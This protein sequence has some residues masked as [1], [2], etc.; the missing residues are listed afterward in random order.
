MKT[1]RFVLTLL[2]LSLVATGLIVIIFQPAR[3]RLQRLA[4]TAS[5]A[6][7]A[8][9]GDLPPDFTARKDCGVDVAVDRAGPDGFSRHANDHTTLLVLGDGTA[10]CLLHREHPL[11]SIRAHARKDSGRRMGSGGF[12]DRVEQHIYGRT[13][14]AHERSIF[15]LYSIRRRSAAQQHVKIARCDQG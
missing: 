14:E 9:A 4:R 11:H 6:L 3:E 1:T 12:R 15:Y 2:A 5:I 13:L 10:A 8:P 7:A